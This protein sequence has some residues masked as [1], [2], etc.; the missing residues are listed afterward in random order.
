[1]SF[2]LRLPNITGSTDR[3]QIAQIKS[4][5]YQ[6]TGQLEWAL[7][8]LNSSSPNV[9]GL[10]SQSAGG[11]TEINAQLTFNDIKS[12]IIKSADIVN[13]YS[14]IIIERFDGEYVAKSD[15]GTYKEKTSQE[16]LKSSDSI[17][18]LYKN[19]QS[20]ISD[21]EDIENRLI[22]VN[23]Y[24]RSGVLY[25]DELGVPI[26]GLEVGQVNIVDGVETF[27]KY[28]RFT[29]DRKSF[30][31]ANDTEVAYIKDYKLYITNVEITGVVYL[32]S[33]DLDTTKGIRLKF[34]RRE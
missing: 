27:N 33:F 19:L 11:I 18:S 34:V 25:T 15:F 2:S 7:N 32:N 12:L 4:Y 17:E 22:E 9:V 13:A 28:A 31:D 3:E 10:T 20:I 29:S 21:V 30:Y 26:Y 24:I 1:M 5:L 16:I 8:A 6:L 14:N 23:A